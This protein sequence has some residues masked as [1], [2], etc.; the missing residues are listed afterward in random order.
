M[1]VGIGVLVLVIVHA[2]AHPSSAATPPVCA[3]PPGH[4]KLFLPELSRSRVLRVEDRG[5][6]IAIDGTVTAAR[7]PE[8]P[9]LPEIHSLADG[10][11][12]IYVDER[13][14]VYLWDPTRKRL[15]DIGRGWLVAVPARGWLIRS[16]IDPDGDELRL[17]DIDPDRD[18]PR[19][20]EVWRLP[21]RSGVVH[22]GVLD[23]AI[24][25]VARDPL[26]TTLV[27]IAG[28]GRV[29]TRSITLPDALFVASDDAI[30]GHRVL[31]RGRVQ[32]G[33][34]ARDTNIKP[35][36]NVFVLDLDQGALR[37]VGMATGD[38]NMAMNV[39]QPRVKVRWADHDPGLPDLDTSPVNRVDP[40]TEHVQ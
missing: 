14:R 13:Q 2:C 19:L 8:G 11:S 10:R 24:A 37:Q 12:M 31:L 20:R 16:P 18:H 30:R 1:Q 26:G 4:E 32:L 6:R 23:G 27:C 34:T 40:T 7:W 38:W 25:A 35:T 22:A 36:A 21:A 15:A 33:G 17:A 39:P 5:G 28:P 29:S 9:L 3:S